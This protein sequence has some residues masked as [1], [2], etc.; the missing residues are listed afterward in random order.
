MGGTLCASLRGSPTGARR[1]EA[2]CFTTPREALY[3]TVLVHNIPQGRPSPTINYLLTI[4]G[5]PVQRFRLH[6]TV[7][8]HGCTALTLRATRHKV[9]GETKCKLKHYTLT[10]FASSFPY[11]IYFTCKFWSFALDSFFV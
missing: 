1:S 10:Q 4:V 2:T 3:I 9:Y 8:P 6:T 5:G 7:A 11:Q